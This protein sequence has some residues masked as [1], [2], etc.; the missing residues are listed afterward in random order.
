MA[1]GTDRGEPRGKITGISYQHPLAFWLGSASVTLGVLLHL[2]FYFA[3][4]DNNYVLAGSTPDAPFMIGMVLIFAGL[5]ATAYGLF[6]RLSEV[7]RGYVSRIKVRALDEAP[8]KASHVGLLLVMAA[9]IT[10]D[11]M[12]PTTLAFIAPGAAAE[13]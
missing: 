6:P 9:A 12:K 3:A 1:I 4:A 11:V 7:S 5:A 10:I 2:P 13:Y 8:I